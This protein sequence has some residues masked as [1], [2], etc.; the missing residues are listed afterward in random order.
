MRA[1][2]FKNRESHTLP[3][4]FSYIQCKSTKAHRADMN[5][6]FMSIFLTASAGDIKVLNLHLQYLSKPETCEADGDR[7]LS[8]ENLAGIESLMAK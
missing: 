3:C 2:R 8:C 4:R 6:K 1:L 7:K 5:W